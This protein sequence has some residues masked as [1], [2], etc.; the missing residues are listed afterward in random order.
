M[1]RTR[2]RTRRSSASSSRS[3][4][5]PLSGRSRDTPRPT[6]VCWV[7][8]SRTLRRAAGTEGRVR[9]ADAR[10]FRLP[11]HAPQRWRTSGAGSTA[12]RRACGT[13]GMLGSKLI[14]THLLHSNPPN[15]APHGHIGRGEVAVLVL[16]RD[17]GVELRRHRRR[18]ARVAPA[19]DRR[20][21][22][23]PRSRCSAAPCSA[24]PSCSVSR[25]DPP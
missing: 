13:S 5:R 20:A 24:A 4:T 14:S 22:C 17:D 1:C 23:R 2:I 21:V 8:R 10:R 6:F 15:P 11:R 3:C 7:G 25:G 18:R 9:R 12:S 19:V 16:E